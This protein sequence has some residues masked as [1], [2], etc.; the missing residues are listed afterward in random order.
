MKQLLICLL[1]IGI[2]GC[3]SNAE[4][5]NTPAGLLKKIYSLAQKEDYERLQECIFPFVDKGL[6]DGLLQGIREKAARG[7]GAYSH[8]ALKLLIDNHLDKLE[9]AAGRVLEWCKREGGDA[10]SEDKRVA[11][12]AKDRPQDL[13]MFDYRNVHI[14]IIKF[15]GVHQL[16]FWENLTDLTRDTRESDQGDALHHHDEHEADSAAHNKEEWE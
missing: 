7:D 13:T 6:P 2:A 4:I 12:I 5:K 3:G 10:L 8:K 15:E 14:I 1:L 11:E 9:P 16:L